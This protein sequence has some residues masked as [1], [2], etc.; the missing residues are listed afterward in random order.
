MENNKQEEIVEN[1]KQEEIVEIKEE[2][3]LDNEKT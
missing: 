2:D 3:I 1:D